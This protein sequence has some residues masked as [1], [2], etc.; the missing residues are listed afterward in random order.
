MR[1]LLALLSLTATIALLS[2]G[3]ATPSHNAHGEQSSADVAADYYT[4]PMHP[5]VRSDKPGVCPI[6]HMDLVKTSNGGQ[7]DGVSA[8]SLIALSDHEQLLANVST[9]VVTSEVVGQSIRGYGVLEIPEPN[10]KVISARFSGRIERLFADAPGLR[11]KKGEPLFEVYSPDIIQGAN[12]YRQTK[13]A[14]GPNHGF[15]LNA[16]RVKLQLLGLSDGQIAALDTMESVPLVMDYLSPVSG[17]IMEKRVV[18]GVYITEG[19]SLFDVSDLSTLWNIAEVYDADAAVVR[20][21]DR[22]TVSVAGHSIQ[23]LVSF[24]YP[25]VDPQTRTIKIRITVGNPQG[26]LRANMYTETVFQR[27]KG[28]SLVVPVGAVL[29]TGKRNI[30]YVL[31]GKDGRYEAREIGL[32]ARIDG[33]YEITWGLSEGERIVREGG[34]LIDSESRLKIDGGATH[35]HAVAGEGKGEGGERPGGHQH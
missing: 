6:C 7:P 18:E 3:K 9:V 16:A 29:M 21:G 1:T 11:I 14:G 2:C 12:E 17:V 23:G 8:D 25:V 33:N 10:K 22:A 13:S 4:C 27:Q 19:A 31:A 20:T 5:Q 28:E 15:L 30:V 34:Y 32:G 24:I 35:Q 26:N